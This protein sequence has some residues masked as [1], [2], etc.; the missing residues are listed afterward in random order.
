MESD[1][2]YVTLEQ[3]LCPIC[4]KAEDTGNLLLDRRL[5]PTFERKTV[6]G[7]GMCK[8][9]ASKTEEYVALVGVKNAPAQG[10]DL[11]KP[12]DADRTGDLM[13]VRR[14]VWSKLF[15][16]PE[17]K[18]LAFVDPQAIERLKEMAK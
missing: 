2:S 6:T 11:M 5:L 7:Y 14:S 12:E 3:H 13:W 10:S 16:L 4:G 18:V 1:K 8:D 9:C 15:N 17:P